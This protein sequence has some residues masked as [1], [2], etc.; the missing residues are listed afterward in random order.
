MND[1]AEQTPTSNVRQGLGLLC[2]AA[3]GIV[4]GLVGKGED[5]AT[6]PFG[7]GPSIGEQIARIIGGLGFILGII[8]LAYIAYGLLRDDKG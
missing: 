6:R 2:I 8:A 1:G 4:I 7:E 3:I 5:D